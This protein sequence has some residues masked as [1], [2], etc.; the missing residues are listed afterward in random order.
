MILG[1]LAYTMINKSLYDD[2]RKPYANRL[3]TLLETTA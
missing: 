2:D 3:R 1:C